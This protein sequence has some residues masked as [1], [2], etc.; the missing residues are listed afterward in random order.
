M[1]TLEGEGVKSWH[2][3]SSFGTF[4]IYISFSIKTTPRSKGPMKGALQATSNL[5]YRLLLV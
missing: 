2:Q 3:K 5:M 4:N 1:D